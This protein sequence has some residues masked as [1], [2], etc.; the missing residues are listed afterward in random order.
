[1]Q[2]A[3]TGWTSFERCRPGRPWSTEDKQLLEVVAGL[4][5]GALSRELEIEERAQLESEYHHSKKMEAVGQL[6]GGVAHDFNNLLT[7]IQGYAQL[8][9]ST[10]PRGVPGRCRV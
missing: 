7:T 4:I 5:S 3:A 9:M 1:M 2:G 8:L 10:S 6:A